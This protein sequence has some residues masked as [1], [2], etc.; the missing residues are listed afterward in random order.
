MK[1]ER[2]FRFI[3]TKESFNITEVSRNTGLSK[4]YVS[5][6]IKELKERELVWGIR[7]LY[8]DPIG[9]LRFW[10]VKKRKLLRKVELARFYFP[11]PSKIKD[12]LK[13]YAISGDFGAFLLSGETPGISGIVYLKK[14]KEG[15][16][17]FKRPRG[18]FLVLVGY[19]EDIFRYT[20]LI[21]GFRVVFIPQLAADLMM[22]GIYGD[23]G[24]DLLK[25][26]LDA[27]RKI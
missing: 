6:I 21:K 7:N 3:F 10:G 11:F 27:G 4:S 14:W 17:K 23:V 12:M 16:N 20:T 24:I 22:E 9:V 13:D 2:I 15:Y 18:N 26:W 8:Y 19:D 25:R 1:W 5:E